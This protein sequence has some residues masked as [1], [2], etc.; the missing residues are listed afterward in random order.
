MGDS[1]EWLKEHGG[2]FLDSY[3]ILDRERRIEGF[4]QAFVGLLGMRSSQRRKLAG[5]RCYEHLKLDI[6]RNDCIAIKCLERNAPVKMSEIRGDTKVGEVVL[7]VSA[8]PLRDDDGTVTGV[9]VT[10]RDVTD[11]RRLK[12]RYNEERTRSKTDRDSLL[13]IIQDR[14]SEIERLKR[15]RSG[16]EED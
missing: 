10:H 8:V 1:K 11:E 5:A 9:L 15:L 14:D 4:N 7:E 2:V 6:C 13:R 16:N 3:F 12:E